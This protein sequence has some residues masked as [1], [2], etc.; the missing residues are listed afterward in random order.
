[1]DKALV[2]VKAERLQAAD[3][4]HVLDS[5]ELTLAVAL[6]TRPWALVASIEAAHEPL[7]LAMTVREIAW[8]NEPDPIA[9]T[10]PPPPLLSPGGGGDSTLA[11]IP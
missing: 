1:M 10:I 3:S 9:E 2:L 4:F 5:Q 7:A 8:A 6:N 11:F